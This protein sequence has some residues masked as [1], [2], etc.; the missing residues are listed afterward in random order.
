MPF[1]NP[2]GLSIHY[3]IEGNP[4]SPPLMLHHGWTSDIEAWRDFG[5][6]DA[7]A[8][9]YQIILIDARG[10]GLSDAPDG[11]EHY[12]PNVFVADAEAVLDVV[13]V[14]PVTYW[15][16]SMGAA[17]GFELVVNSPHLISRFI[18]GGMHPYGNS[19][20][21]EPRPTKATSELRERGME[22]F[23]EEREKDLGG[24]IV[25]KLRNRL[26]A[27]SAN[28]LA[29]A[30]EAWAGWRGVADQVARIE[31]QTLLYAGTG[32][33]V[34]HD[35]AERAASEMSNA[36]FIS[37]PRISHDAGFAASRAVLGSIQ[38]FL[39]SHPH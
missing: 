5:Y 24:K 1:I 21:G 2:N 20:D 17:V 12:T 30:G 16:Y 26:L 10:H 29:S 34:F 25:P 28:G 4:S 35:G 7:L 39:D 33:T 22:G 36:S 11:A 14:G 27:A 3:E 32:D 13:E 38:E 9:K 19:T 18:A 6:I 15:G 31:T 8:D 23:V 37:V